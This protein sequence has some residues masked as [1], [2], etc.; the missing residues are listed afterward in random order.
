MLT[1]LLDSVLGFPA[2]VFRILWKLVIR[3]LLGLN[4][5]VAT[6][7]GIWLWGISK[8]ITN[9][10]TYVYMY[11]FVCGW[12]CMCVFACVCICVRMRVYIYM[13]VYV[14]TM[15]IYIYIYKLYPLEWK[16]G[17]YKRGSSRCQVCNSIKETE[18]FSSTVTGES[19]KINH[20][21]CC[22]DKYLIYLLTCKIC[23]KQY[24]G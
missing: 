19:Y 23:A 10:F 15:Y 13:C 11:V 6:W 8:E 12:L 21:L 5:L 1:F 7:C 16:R 18:I 4:W 14:C 20:R 2:L 9:S 22:N 3:L 24:T 17:S